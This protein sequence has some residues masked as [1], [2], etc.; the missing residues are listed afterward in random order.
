YCDKLILLNNGMVHAQG[1]PQEVLDYRIIEEVY[2]TT[3]VVQENP[4][5]R[6]PYV[7]I[8]P[9]EENKRRER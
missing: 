4:I 6:K 7:L 1:T 3:V 5:S 8:V 9:E 2:K